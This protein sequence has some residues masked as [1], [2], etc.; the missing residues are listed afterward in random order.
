[1]ENFYRMGVGGWFLEASNIIPSKRKNQ[2]PPRSTTSRRIWAMEGI[3]NKVYCQPV[4]Q[5][6]YLDRQSYS[7]NRRAYS[8]NHRHSK[9]MGQGPKNFK[10]KCLDAN[11]D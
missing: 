9:Y 6:I 5:W 11:F 1:M 4:S 2:T 3:S 10:C 8:H 7:N